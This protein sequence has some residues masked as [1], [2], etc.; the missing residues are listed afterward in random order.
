VK[1]RAAEEAALVRNSGAG[2]G[3]AAARICWVSTAVRNGRGRRCWS[4]ARL[5]RTTDGAGE[6]EAGEREVWLARVAV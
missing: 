1:N 2:T 6:R 4:L 5:N 3:A